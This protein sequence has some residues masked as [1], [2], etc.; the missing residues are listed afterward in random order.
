MSYYIIMTP[1][2]GKWLFPGSMSTANAVVLTPFGL[3]QDFAFMRAHR[4]NSDQT[5]KADD[6]ATLSS[7][8]AFYS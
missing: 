4:D 3:E 8:S 2:N 1:E 7:L 5:K 6:C